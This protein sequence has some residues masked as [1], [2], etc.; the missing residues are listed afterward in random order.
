MFNWLSS[1]FS[2]YL[3]QQE[4]QF[5][6]Y[7]SI[8]ENEILL[9]EKEITKKNCIFIEREIVWFWYGY[10]GPE[11]IQL[12]FFSF[13]ILFLHVSEMQCISYI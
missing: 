10:I 12:R 5:P 2:V 9:A 6:I 4:Y 3:F 8:D 1:G 11:V 13:L 7:F